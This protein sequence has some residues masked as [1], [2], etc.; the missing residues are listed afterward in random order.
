MK[1]CLISA[2]ISINFTKRPTVNN[3][4]TQTKIETS[5]CVFDYHLAPCIANLQPVVDRWSVTWSRSNQASRHSESPKSLGAQIE[6]CCCAL[7]RAQRDSSDHITVPPD[8]TAVA[9]RSLLS[10]LKV[11]SSCSM[12]GLRLVA[13]RVALCTIIVIIIMRA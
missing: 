10:D 5:W 7:E 1:Q 3:K 12:C 2:N 13:I 8:L 4:K 9:V 6:T 11:F